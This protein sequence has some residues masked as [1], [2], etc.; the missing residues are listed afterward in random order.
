MDFLIKD[1]TQA[2]I[3]GKAYVHWK[4]LQESYRG[5]IGDSY[6]DEHA[7]PAH[8][9][10]IS[11]KWPD[12]L[13]VAVVDGTGV[14]FAGYGKSLDEDLENCGEVFALYVL[15]AY[16]RKK[17]GFS[18]MQEALHRIEQYPSVALWVLEGNEKAISFYEKVGFRADGASKMMNLGKPVM[19]IRM[20]LRKA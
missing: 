3:E 14:G 12:N 10:Q 6:L 18:L 4:S 1:M 13:L 15:Q 11:R 20:L 19:A 7:T 2:E 8:C 16:Q 17:I 9:L 5:L